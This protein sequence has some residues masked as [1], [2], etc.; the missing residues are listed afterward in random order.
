VT[1]TTNP[2]RFAYVVNRGS[3]NVS[4]YTLDVASG[5]L[6]TITGS[7]FPAGNMPVA[8][9][10]DPTGKYLFVVNQGGSTLSAYLIDRSSGAL[11]GVAGSPF[12]TGALPSSLVLSPDQS[13]VFVSNQSDNTVSI[14]GPLSDGALT[15]NFI[16]TL[17]TG[18]APR[19][20]AIDINAHLAASR[21]RTLSNRARRP[22]LPMRREACR[23]PWWSTGW[24]NSS[25]SPIKDPTTFP[26][27]PS[28]PQPAP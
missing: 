4:A 2:P 28:I 10:V 16:P 1:C 15:A 25:M 18:A 12:P 24:V 9:A 14:L 7:P 19:S 13:V 22:A 11:T 8:I 23:F 21:R 27:L 26:R 17:A 5:A 3:N 6:T 20:L